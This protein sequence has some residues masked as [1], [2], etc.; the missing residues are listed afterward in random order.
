MIRT[1]LQSTLVLALLVSIAG[2]P[3]STGLK[4]HRDTGDLAR[5]SGA[6]QC[7]TVVRK[8]RFV[9]AAADIGVSN[10][11]AEELYEISGGAAKDVVTGF[12]PAQDRGPTVERALDRIAKNA[13]KNAFYVEV[14]IRNLGGLNNVLGHSDADV[15]FAEMTRITQK[16]IQS[17][18]AGS[19]SFRHGGDEFSFVVIGPSATQEGIEMALE[20]ADMEISKYIADKGLA[21][22]EH[23]KHIGEAS[24]YGAGII[25]GVSR[26]GTQKTAK[27]VYGVADKVVER[28]KG[29]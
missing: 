21:E 20:Q 4:Q 25:F 1:T 26:I 18:G 5:T 24:K 28:K 15:V 12:A 7:E 9:G 13:N 29:E 23:P 16:H 11:N 10:T 27:D 19:C 8:E 3:A 14:D 22:I 17:L 2:C 6:F